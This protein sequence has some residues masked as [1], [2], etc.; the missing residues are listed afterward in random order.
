LSS[1]RLR[2]KRRKAIHLQQGPYG[3]IVTA[4]PERA[5]AITAERGER[6]VPAV[7][8]GCT[9]AF[10]ST[11]RLTINEKKNACMNQFAP[12]RTECFN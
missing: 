9:N 11:S 8:G 6:S 2:I 4:M 7:D 10:G 1:K 12:V 3:C 5:C